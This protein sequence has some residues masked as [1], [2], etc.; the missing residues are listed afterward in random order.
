MDILKKIPVLCILLCAVAM[1]PCL[2]D[3]TLQPRNIVWGLTVI[4]LLFCTKDIKIGPPLYF[5]LGLLFFTVLSGANAINKSEWLYFTLRLTMVLTYISV[6][7]IDVKSLTK[8]MLFLG[9]VFTA[10]FWYQYSQVGRFD[11]CSGLTRQKN[12]WAAAHFFVLPFCYNAIKERYWVKLAWLICVSMLLN[13]LLLGTK[14]A[15]L[16]VVVT[17]FFVDKRL[18]AVL[19]SLTL[20]GGFVH[21]DL[22]AETMHLRWI[23]WKPTMAMALENPFGVGAGNWWI[24]FPTYAPDIQ[25]PNAYEKVHFRFPHNDYL[26]IL[27]ETGIAGMLCFLGML[28]AAIK[29]A[30]EK[31]FIV[32]GIVGYMVICF[33]SA[34]R[35][36]V[37]SLLIFSTFISMSFTGIR[38]KQPRILITIA[39]LALVVF[40]FR[41]RGSYYNKVMDVCVKAKTELKIADTIK[42]YSVFSTMTYTG[43]PYE[44]CYG[45]SWLGINDQIAC[46]YLEKA[47]A[48]NPGNI[49]VI[50]GMG[51]AQALQGKE[52]VRYFKEA[53]RIKPS[54]KGAQEDLLKVKF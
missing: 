4:T 48:V 38:I 18:F 14:S 45:I 49:F 41:L 54:Y 40:G 6:V 39:V 12:Y 3:K 15:I 51:I 31:K 13:I 50:D 44:W 29:F 11:H 21:R 26:W 32:I 19:V 27:A 7:R 23:H 33:F 25:Y 34:P 5:G 1:V 36:R 9:C 35:M 24:N 47:Y 30:W 28:L 46:L 22:I 17:S 2:Y 52:S 16:A 10:Y 20:V 43:F 8:A 42:G 37:F 53:L